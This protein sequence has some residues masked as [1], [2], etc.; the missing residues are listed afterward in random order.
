VIE[1]LREPLENGDITI[2]RGEEAV[3]LPARSMVVVACVLLDSVRMAA[4]SRRGGLGSR[5][6]HCVG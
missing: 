6:S 5:R 3:T 1:A 4:P 2:A